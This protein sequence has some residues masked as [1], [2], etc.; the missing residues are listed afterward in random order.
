MNAWNPLS[1]RS[2]E[3]SQQVLEDKK[4][5]RKAFKFAVKAHKDM[6]RKSGEPFIYHPLSVA[7]IA[8]GEIGLGTTSIVCAL[9]HDVVEDTEFT[10]EDIR[11]L[12]GDKVASIIDGLTKIK[13]IFDQKSA[14]VQAENF[15]K[16]LITLSDDVRVI[17]IKLADR[18]HNMR[19]LDAISPEKQL[20][21]ASETMHLYAPLANRLGLHTMKS[22][23]QD[24]AL[25]HID[26]EIYRSISTK[27]KETAKSRAQFTNKFIHPIKQALAQ[28]GIVHTITTRDKSIYSIWEKMKTKEIPFEEIYDIF[29]IRIVIK[30]PVDT[31]KSD[32]W[33]VYSAITDIY[34]P[35]MDRLRDWISNPKANGYE[36]LHTTVMSHTGQWVEIQIRSIRMDEIAEKGYAAHW[37][38]KETLNISSRLDNWLD[39]I[40]EMIVSPETDALSFID[41]VKGYFFLDEISVFTPQGELRTLPA[42]STVLD[43]AYAIHSEVGNCCIGAKVDK[44]LA[45]ISYELHNGEQ[46]EILTSA[47]QTPKEEWLNIVVTTRAKSNI[48]L[49]LKKEK[50]KYFKHGKEKLEKYFTQYD[51]PFTHENIKN[52]LSATN[53]PSLLELYFAVSHDKI[54]QKDVKH[55]IAS[56]EKTGWLRFINLKNS[57]KQT[58]ENEKA[59]KKTPYLIDTTNIAKHVNGNVES[60][61]YEISTCCNPIPGD[62]IIAI[63]AS[64]NQP[65]KVHR[66]KCPKATELISSFGNNFVR[67]EWATKEPVAFLTGIKLSGIDKMGMINEISRIIFAD[68]KINIK[69]FHMDVNNGLTEGEVMLYIQ[70][71]A[72][73]K[74]LLKNLK[75]IEGIKK[76]SRIN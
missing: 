11:G 66:A 36:A 51:L 70:D 59:D 23:L 35:N 31:E 43:F 71:T 56:T 16:L 33:K 60:M 52:F 40:R 20:K 68:L 58:V 45:P 5:V 76:V 46:I 15:K 61:G 14:S 62:E 24:L 53:Y 34:R 50:K 75:G 9:L 72:I 44:K 21:I 55:F 3:D 18:L 48:K 54:G 4:V 37:K 29:A 10:L 1:R 12:F 6:R 28:L 49:A 25:K 69:S 63:I 2:A 27:L 67:V 42:T 22:E 32:C 8:A 65:Y 64:D 19:T 13:G 38:Y 74:Q 26:P 41:D 30:S 73:L 7:T 17:L 39:R 47:K 57:K